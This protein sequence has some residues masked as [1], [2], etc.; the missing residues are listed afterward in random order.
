MSFYYIISAGGGPGSRSYVRE[1][2]VGQGLEYCNDRQ[3]AKRFEAPWPDV[4]PDPVAAQA[5]AASAARAWLAN[6]PSTLTH[7]LV[8]FNDNAFTSAVRA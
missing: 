6:Y 5:V 3:A 7:E 4:E 1:G 8:G 2:R